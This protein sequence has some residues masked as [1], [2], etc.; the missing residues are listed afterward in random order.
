MILP[1][2]GTALYLHFS[3]SVSEHTNMISEHKLEKDA[4]PIGPGTP[5]LVFRLVQFYIISSDLPGSEFSI[6][7]RKIYIFF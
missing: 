1:L 5:N 2:F 6:N 4:G 7:A 3:I